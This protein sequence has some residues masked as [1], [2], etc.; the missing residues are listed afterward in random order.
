MDER[1]LDFYGITKEATLELGFRLRGGGSRFDANAV[2]DRHLKL[3]MDPNVLVRKGKFGD[4]QLFD[5]ALEEE[6]GFV[7]PMI[8]RA[9]YAEHVLSLDSNERFSPPNNPLLICTPAGEF[10][11][12]VGEHGIDTTSWELKLNARPFCAPG[13]MVE[14]RNAHC[15]VDLCAAPVAQKARLMAVE[16]VALRLYSGPLYAKYNSALRS[17]V[18]PLGKPSNSYPTT[19]QVLLSAIH[20]L[21]RIAEIPQGGAVYR[22]LSG[23]ALPQEFFEVDE[24]GFAGGVEPSFMSTTLDDE[25][26]RKYSGVLEGKEATIFKLLLDRT[27]IGADISWVSQFT[28]EV[29]C[30][31]YDRVM[32]LLPCSNWF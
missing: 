32:F 5:S 18:S 11:F 8:L 21:S 4:I 14:G 12:V 26:A 30:H 17:V 27:S 9:M 10:L 13:A 6:L 3:C 29:L 15:L 25:V 23:I 1:T 20:K 19:I 24:Q 16:I 2:A 31:F 7:D 22:G 28:H